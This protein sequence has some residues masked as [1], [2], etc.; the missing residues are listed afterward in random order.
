MLGLVLG[1]VTQELANNVGYDSVE[2]MVYFNI[3]LAK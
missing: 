1:L 3:L 2:G